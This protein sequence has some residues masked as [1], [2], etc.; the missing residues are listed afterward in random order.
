MR[1][2]RSGVRNAITV[3]HQQHGLML[4]PLQHVF[5]RS[6]DKLHFTDIRDCLARVTLKCIV[7]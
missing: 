2:V 6:W 7:K 1:H 5:L 3:G 4:A